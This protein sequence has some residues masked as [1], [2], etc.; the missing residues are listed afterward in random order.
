VKCPLTVKVDEALTTIC[1]AAI[2]CNR[3][4]WTRIS[5]PLGSR[6]GKQARESCYY[7]E[8]VLHGILHG[9]S[10]E[11]RCGAVRQYCR[12]VDSRSVRMLKETDLRGVTSTRLYPLDVRAGER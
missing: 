1:Q 8:G 7:N 10:L 3:S 12:V 4:A 2:A 9:I 6:L 5:V 11:V